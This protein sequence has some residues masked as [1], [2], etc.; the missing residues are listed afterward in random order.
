MLAR[1][2]VHATTLMVLITAFVST[3]GRERIA[4][5]ILMTAPMLLAAVEQPVMIELH[6]SSASVHMDA[7]VFSVTLKMLVSATHA[8][9]AP[10]VIQTLS[11]AKLF[12]LAHLATAVL[13]VITIWMSAR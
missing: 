8:M 4:A 10:T 12:A 3:A 7:Q 1:M 6:L 13:P 9:K 5:K 2:V 11:M